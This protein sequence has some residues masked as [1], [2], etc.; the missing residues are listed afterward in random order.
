MIKSR[1][2]YESLQT[3]TSEEMAVVWKTNSFFEKRFP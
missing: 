3:R 2:R 1:W